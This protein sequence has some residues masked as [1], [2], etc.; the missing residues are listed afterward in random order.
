[1]ADKAISELISATEVTESDLLVLEQAGTAKKLSGQT[2]TTYLLRFVDGHGGIKSIEKTGTSGLVDTYT[3]TM[4]DESTSTFTVANGEKG[5]RGDNTYTWIKYSSSMPTEDEQMYDTPDNYMGI[6]TG[7]NSRA[8]GAHTEYTWFQIK[9]EKGDTGAAANIESQSVQYQA[10]SSGTITPSGAWSDTVPT[11]A[12]GQYLWT[13][14]I[15]KF[16]TG[17]EQ[18]SYSVSRFGL[19]GSGTVV[20]VAGV[21]PDS[22]GNVSLSAADVGAIPNVAGATYNTLTLSLTPNW[23]DNRQ[24]VAASGVHSSNLVI[25]SPVPASHT[26]YCECGVRCVSQATGYLT[27]ECTEVPSEAITVNVV[28]PR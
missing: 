10:S 21:A 23:T 25:V 6:Y 14:S 11:V 15:L 22:S 17:E 9:G 13:R 16:N 1:M 27:F 18:I 3:I 7:P 20:T 4:A 12:Q 19:D 26:V 24:T 28:I 8:P 2:L 5:D